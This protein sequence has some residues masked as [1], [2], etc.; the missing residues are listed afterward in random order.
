MTMAEQKS[1]PGTD[2]A[3]DASRRADKLRYLNKSDYGQRYHAGIGGKSRNQITR[4]E[5]QRADRPLQRRAE[6]IE[7]EK[8]KKQ[9]GETP[10]QEKRSEK[11]PVLAL[12]QHS[13]RLQPPDP[14]QYFRISP[15]AE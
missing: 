15:V 7:G 4:S 6:H 3:H 5:S 13:A 11:T 8:I 14:M 10:V 2:Y 12:H 9:V 1:R